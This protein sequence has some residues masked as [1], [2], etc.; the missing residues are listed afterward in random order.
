MHDDTGLGRAFAGD[1]SLVLRQGS[2]GMRAGP[3]PR[4]NAPAGATQR[5]APR[6]LVRFGRML[7]A[8]GV[9]EDGSRV[10][11]AGAFAAMRESQ[12]SLPRISEQDPTG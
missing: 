3:Q 9:A 11:P 2:K 5:A 7:L 1:L 8:D 12:I 10:L 6:E 4:S